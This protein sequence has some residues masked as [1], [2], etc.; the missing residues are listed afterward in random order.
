MIPRWPADA[1]SGVQHKDVKS[2]VEFK[3]T[4]SPQTVSIQSNLPDQKK[5]SALH[6]NFIKRARVLT[7]LAHLLTLVSNCDA[8]IKL[9]SEARHV[10]GIQCW[11]CSK[12]DI[13]ESPQPLLT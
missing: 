13:R 6:A 1:G 3:N 8:A 12:T 9:V 2:G 4:L 10:K 11:C 5:Q 7:S